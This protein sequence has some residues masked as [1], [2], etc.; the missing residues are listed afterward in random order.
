MTTT[1]GG[2]YPAVNSDSDATINGLTV[3]KG[4]GSQS[5]NTAVGSGAL[6]GSNGNNGQVAVG[7]QS[8]YTNTSGYGTAIGYRSLYLNTTGASNTAIGNSAL[9]SNTTGGANSALGE[10]ALYS[11]TTASNNTAVGYQAGYSNTT[12]AQNT[13]LGLSAGRTNTVGINNTFVG[14]EAGYSLTTGNANTFIGRSSAGYGNYGAGYLVTTGSNN[15]IIGGYNGNSGGLDIRTASNYIVL[16]D[17]DGNPRAYSDGSGNWFMAGGLGVAGSG[18]NANTL[19]G[20]NLPGPTSGSST[21]NTSVIYFNNYSTSAGLPT[22]IQNWA[23]NATFAIGTHSGSGDN[24]VRIGQASTTGSGYIWNGNYCNIYAGAYTNASDYRI[25]A[26]VSNLA[27]GAL[28]KVEQMR[29]VNYT[30]IQVPDE[31]DDLPPAKQ[32]IGF[33]AHELQEIVPEIVTGEK[34]AVDNDGVTPLHQGVDYAKLTVILVK[35]IQELKAEVDS[36]KQQLGK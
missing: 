28:S 21:A 12:G 18:A 13:F 19:R 29:P 16:S 7:Y 6:N 23:S 22:F 34:D 27:F 4:G 20:I 3:G 35:A 30:V 36:L 9:S 26:N 2:S 1:I 24:I 5:L 33:I 11:N 10:Q 25:K 31:D 15:T 14:G 32:E 8:M 17:G